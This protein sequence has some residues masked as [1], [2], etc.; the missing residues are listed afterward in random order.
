MACLFPVIITS[1][2]RWARNDP[3]ANAKFYTCYHGTRD[4]GDLL[5]IIVTSW[6]YN[7]PRIANDANPM[8]DWRFLSF[9]FSR[10]QLLEKYFLEFF[11][12]SLKIMSHVHI[13]LWLFMNRFI[14]NIWWPKKTTTQWKTLSF[15]VTTQP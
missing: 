15:V 12:I 6:V 7:T 9:I 13:H 10:S 1:H 14:N 8:K 3:F 11:Y 4:S 2:C 5:V